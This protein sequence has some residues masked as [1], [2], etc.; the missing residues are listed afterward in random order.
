VRPLLVAAEVDDLALIEALLDAGAS[1]TAANRFSVTP[2]DL[3]AGNGDRA[4]LER[5]LAAGA[6]VNATS[7]EG[8][9]PLMTAAR[10]GKLDA[11]EA[12]LAHGATVDTAEAWRGQTALMGPQARATRRRHGADQGRREREREVEGGL[13]RCCSRCE[14][15]DRH[16]APSA[17]PRRA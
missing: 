2:L 16:A 17:R 8:Q 9:T 5:L 13:R 11:V 12:L 14:R 3:A 10:T 15:G 7:R 6:S 1:A 4:A